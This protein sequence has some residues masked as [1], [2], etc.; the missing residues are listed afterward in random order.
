VCGF[1]SAGLTA[2]AA[3]SAAASAPKSKV[4][5]HRVLF[6]GNSITLHGP[7]PAIGWSGNWGMAASAKEKDY[8]HLVLRALARPAE[9]APESRILNIATF[10][11]QYATA[12]VNPYLKTASGFGPDLIIVAIGENVPKLDSPQAKAQFKASLTKLLRGL[13][14]DARPTIVVRSCFWPNKDKDQ[15]LKEACQEVGGTFVDISSLAKDEANYARSERKIQHRGVA[16]HPGDKGM[17]AITK[18]ILK[19][20]GIKEAH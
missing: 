16:A 18:A 6:V 14:G 5:Y 10:E 1:A 13:Q 4:Q 8:V 12:D 20:L 9:P 15:M 7:N 19:S 2:W 17:Q 3:N 11:R